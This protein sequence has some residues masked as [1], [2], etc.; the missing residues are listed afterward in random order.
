MLELFLKVF[1]AG[2]ELWD[3]KEKHKYI[4]RLLELKKEYYNEFNKPDD[5]RS[6]AVLDNITFEL[7][8][9]GDSFASSSRKP[10]AQN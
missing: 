3:D 5:Q 1:A 9:L 7:R 10:D 2:L 4:D 8:I 6:D